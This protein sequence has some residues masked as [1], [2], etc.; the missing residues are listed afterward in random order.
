MKKWYHSKM[1]YTNAIGIAVI[2]ITAF[3]YEGVSTEVVAS[4]A[5]IPGVINL[6]LRTITSQGL[7][8]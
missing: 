2:L 4:E 3:G 8:K 6:I 1:L 7:G 5:A